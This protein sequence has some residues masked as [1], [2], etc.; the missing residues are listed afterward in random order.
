VPHI[1]VTDCSLDSNPNKQHRFDNFKVH[2]L[3]KS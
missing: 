2:Q 1:E 3:S